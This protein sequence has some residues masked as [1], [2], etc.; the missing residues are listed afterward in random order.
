M[1]QAETEQNPQID[2]LLA[3]AKATDEADLERGRS[4]DDDRRPEGR[5]A[6]REAGAT[7]A[8]SACPGTRRRRT[9]PTRTAAS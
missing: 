9:S 4:D 5:T 2:A 1:K 3:R 8:S 7:S 6:S